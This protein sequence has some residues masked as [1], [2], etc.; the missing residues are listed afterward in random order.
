MG[1]FIILANFILGGAA[2]KEGGLFFAYVYQGRGGN[3]A[4]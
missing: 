3:A 1:V 4:F 2:G